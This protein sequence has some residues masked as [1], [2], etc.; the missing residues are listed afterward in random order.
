MADIRLRL[1]ELGDDLATAPHLVFF[2][3]DEI[4]VHTPVQ[5]ADRVAEIVRESARTAGRLLFGTF[6]VDFPLSVAIVDTY[7]DAK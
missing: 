7:A 2:L 4:M 3:H 1:R 5:Y 6:P